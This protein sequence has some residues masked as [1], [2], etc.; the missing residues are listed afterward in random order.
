MARWQVE[1][2]PNPLPKPHPLPT[3]WGG[4][5]GAFPE[6]SG[7]KTG[8]ETARKP[9][10]RIYG[11]ETQLS[12]IECAT[13]STLG[14]WGWGTGAGGRG[15]LMGPLHLFSRGGWP[16]GF[17]AIGGV[18]F[19]PLCGAAHHLLSIMI[20]DDECR[21]AW[22]CRSDITVATCGYKGPKL[23]VAHL[24]PLQHP[25]RIAMPRMGSWRCHPPRFPRLAPPPLVGGTSSQR[26][27]PHP[28]PGHL[29]KISIGPPSAGGF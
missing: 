16:S 1:T 19:S 6:D 13:A 24:G 11:P 15:E 14:P 4:G 5:W 23:V 29:V 2:H 3:V 8:P 7:L 22:F 12:Y 27:G 20:H 25:T 28:I 26:C 9:G 17:T 21:L 18:R 10:N